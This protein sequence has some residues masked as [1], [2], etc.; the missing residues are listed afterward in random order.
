LVHSF[1]LVVNYS[2]LALLLYCSVIITNFVPSSV[3]SSSFNID[4][5]TIM[6]NRHLHKNRKKSTL[7]PHA[8]IHLQPVAY[9]ARYFDQDIPKVNTSGY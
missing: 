5:K 9:A 2:F 8:D 7:V 6:P 4:I 3:F 1:L